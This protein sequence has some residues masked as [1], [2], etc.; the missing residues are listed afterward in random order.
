M[1]QAVAGKL[2]AAAVEDD[3]DVDRRRHS[4][5][6]AG[7]AALCYSSPVRRVLGASTGRRQSTT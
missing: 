4:R 2:Y 6:A 3:D 7:A 5:S 1:L